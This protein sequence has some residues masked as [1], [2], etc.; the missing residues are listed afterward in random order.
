MTGDYRE[1]G[2]KGEDPDELVSPQEREQAHDPAV[3]AGTP[4]TA[5]WVAPKQTLWERLSR[6]YPKISEEEA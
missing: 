2:Y 1:P 4:A 6:R 5:P 3:G